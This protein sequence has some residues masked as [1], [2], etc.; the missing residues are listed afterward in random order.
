MYN[1]LKIYPGLCP[2]ETFG[3]DSSSSEKKQKSPNHRPLVDFHSGLIFWN[4]RMIFEIP[5]L[6]KWERGNPEPE[7]FELTIISLVHNK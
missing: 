7:N 3:S 5:A 4:I 2:N 1:K 6:L